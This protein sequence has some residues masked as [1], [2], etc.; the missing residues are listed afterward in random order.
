MK[1]LTNMI[2]PHSFHIP[3]MGI[4]FTIETPLK[5][6]QYGIDSVISLGDDILIEKLRKMLCQRNGLPYKVISPLINDFRAKRITSYLNLVNKL[7]LKQF[8]AFKNEALHSM[9]KIKEYLAM[10]PVQSRIHKEFK[11]LLEKSP[12]P[13]EL[14]KWM[15]KYL[16]RGSIDVNIMT[17]I[18]KETFIKNEKLPSEFNT[19]HAALRGYANS[20]LQSSV[21]FSAGLNPRLFTYMAQFNDFHPDNK[22]EIKKKIIIKVSDYRSALIQGKF[23]ANKGLW[24]SEFRIESGLNCGGHAFASDGTLLGPIL[25]EFMNKRN[26]LIQDIHAIYVKTKSANK[27]SIP[28]KTLPMRISV[29]GG[30][31][32][33]VEHQ[34]L[35]DYYKVD[36]VGWGSPFLLVP[37]ATSVDDFTLNKLVESREKDIY[38]SN[39]SPLG[40]LFN[41]LKNSSKEVEKI[42]R[43]KSGK[44]GSPCVKKYLA[45]NKEFS[46]KGLCTASRK[47]QAIKIKE[48]DKRE[49][50]Y[51]D[52]QRSYDEIVDKECICTGLG[53]TALIVNHLNTDLEGNAVSICPGP[54]IAY[55]TKTM[56]LKEITD[57]IYGRINVISRNDRPNMFIKELQINIEFLK[58]KINEFQFSPSKNKIQ[59]FE[60]IVINLDNGISYYL[61]LFSRLDKRFS[62]LSRN[63]Q[64]Y[65]K[66]EQMS[67]NLLKIEIE[68]LS[69]TNKDM[70]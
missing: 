29:Q 70:D 8:E 40:V 59:N 37:E 24:V 42:A 61:E 30:V 56:S 47:Y 39:V 57:H 13:K 9:D 1:I 44:P 55:F 69:E 31:G 35:L 6:S 18:D 33:A 62:E 68:K 66:V 7:A 38:L 52:Y 28:D 67:L 48:L 63:I 32:S 51:Q 12:G 17:K 36:S 4:S 43:I 21:V 20:D 14:S 16:S 64:D 27:Q 50:S 53:T 65:L 11:K 41:N 26:E 54:N 60:K 3:V 23:L 10:L 15:D 25:T 58:N 22:G 46:E 34:F 45:L 2:K 5:V 19:A 49:L